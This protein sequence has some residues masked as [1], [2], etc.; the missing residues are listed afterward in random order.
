MSRLYM[1]CLNKRSRTCDGWDGKKALQVAIQL[2]PALLYK[3]HALLLAEDALGRQ[4]QVVGGQ[5]PA[6]ACEKLSACAAYT[7]C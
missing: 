6:V 2:L 5:V 1:A 4:P 3:F 7:D